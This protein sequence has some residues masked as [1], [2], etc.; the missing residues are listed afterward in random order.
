MDSL[1]KVYWL[2]VKFQD[3]NESKLRPIVTLVFNDRALSFEVLGVYSYKKKYEKN[4]YYKTFMYKI[5]DWRM[6][7]FKEQ[8][9]IN[10]AR[11][12]EIPFTVLMGQKY[13]GALTQRDIE[14]FK[15]LY[16]SYW[17]NH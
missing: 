16:N 1:L 15:A 6:A 11:P 8:S 17:S 7:N 5:K 9:Y 12:F 13:S 2:Y 14:G 3:K 4:P 10:V